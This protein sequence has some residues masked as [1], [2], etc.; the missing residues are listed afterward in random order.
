[1]D[2]PVRV[3]HTLAEFG[4]TEPYADLQRRSERLPLGICILIWLS[5][6]AMLWTV[7]IYLLYHAVA[8]V[9]RP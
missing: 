7:A 9:F 3:S 4:D 2:N 8:W 1:M 5:A 6:G